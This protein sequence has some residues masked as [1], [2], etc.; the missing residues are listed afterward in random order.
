MNRYAK[1]QESS[2]SLQNELI[3]S[4]KNHIASLESQ[5][6]VKDEQLRTQ[7]VHLQ[8]VLTQKAIGTGST[9][10]RE[11]SKTATRKEAPVY[12]S[13]VQEYKP[14][15]KEKPD[16]EPEVNQEEK[17]KNTLIIVNIYKEAQL[18]KFYSI[19]KK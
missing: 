3:L 7:A 13:V 5:I 9:K 15:S 17:T 14:A 12:S 1:Q 2:N 18:N 16:I 4:L 6:M 11:E 19:C 8:T 10:A